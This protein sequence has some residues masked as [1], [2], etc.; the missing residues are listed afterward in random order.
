[1]KNHMVGHV[2]NT[3]HTMFRHST[4]SV[5][6]QLKELCKR[7]GEEMAVQVQDIYNLLARD[8]LAVLVGVDNTN[9]LSSLPR[10]ERLLRAEMYPI[11]QKTT[12]WFAKPSSQGDRQTMENLV[13]EDD[14]FADN[15]ET[16]VDNLLAAQLGVEFNEESDGHTGIKTEP[17]C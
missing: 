3:R 11:L 1:M 5:K 13:V 14:P 17:F 10:S 15:A 12:E 4:D 6:E 16:D 7:V 2:E 8:Y 9:K